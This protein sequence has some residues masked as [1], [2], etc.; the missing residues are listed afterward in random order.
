MD[1]VFKALADPTRRHLLDALRKRGGQAVGELI[2]G[3]AMSRQAASKH[4]AILAQ[5]QL[6]NSERVGREKLLYLNPVPIQRIADRWIG[7]FEAPRLQALTG[8]KRALEGKDNE[9][10]KGRVRGVY[11]RAG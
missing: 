10:S 4:L 1:D 6:V 9:R 8:L 3:L 2:A 7:N 11:R 5:A